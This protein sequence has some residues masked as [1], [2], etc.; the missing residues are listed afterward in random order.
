MGVK[1]ID[2]FRRGNVYQSWSPEDQKRYDVAASVTLDHIRA[3]LTDEVYRF[4]TPLR[5]PPL[6]DPLARAA[7]WRW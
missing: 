5:W 2:E 4:R 3:K 6:Y 7:A 1:N